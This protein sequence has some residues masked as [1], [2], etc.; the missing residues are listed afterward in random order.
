MNQHEIARLSQK[1]VKESR[2]VTWLSTETGLSGDWAEYHY[3]MAQVALGDRNVQ[4]RT[5]C[6]A[7]ESF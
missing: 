6:E 2:S 3:R 4:I 7:T 1:A 5:P